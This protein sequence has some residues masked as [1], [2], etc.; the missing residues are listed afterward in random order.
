MNLTLLI[1]QSHL[2]IP[3]LL[4]IFGTD[5]G[6]MIN[7][8]IVLMIFYCA[9]GP[10]GG[11]YK[12]LNSKPMDKLGTLSY[13]IYLWQQFFLTKSDWWFNQLPLSLLLLAITV[14]LSYHFIEKPFLRLKS[15]FEARREF[16]ITPTYPSPSQLL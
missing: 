16:G 3:F 10:K 12:I 4:G 7:L 9:F 15:R 5:H 1:T 14:L 2:K 6:L 11:L 8:L 13:G